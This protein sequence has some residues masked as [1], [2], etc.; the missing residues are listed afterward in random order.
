[1]D[2]KNFLIALLLWLALFPVMAQA[3]LSQVF[4]LEEEWTLNTNND[5]FQPQG[6][7]GC[8]ED[9]IL[10]CCHRRGFQNSFRAVTSRR[11]SL[12]DGS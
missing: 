7:V 3:H 9:N 1:M 5:V 2:K 4:E 6:M 11:L 8:V 10:Y 12:Q